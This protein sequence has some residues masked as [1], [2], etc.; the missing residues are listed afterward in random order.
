MENPLPKGKCL[1][2]GAEY[3]LRESRALYAEI[4]CSADCEKEFVRHV[5]EFYQIRA[6]TKVLAWM[7]PGTA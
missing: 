1:R 5:A 6:E 2:C 3:G 4:F 7:P